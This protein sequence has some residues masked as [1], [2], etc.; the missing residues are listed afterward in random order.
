METQIKLRDAA[1]AALACQWLAE[2]LEVAVWE[3]DLV[4]PSIRQAALAQTALAT[5]HGSVYLSGQRTAQHGNARPHPPS[6]W[7]A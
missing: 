2:A 6:A 1:D 4:W 7:A 5:A 3:V